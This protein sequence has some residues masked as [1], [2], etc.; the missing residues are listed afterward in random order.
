MNE[1][2]RDHSALNEVASL[3]GNGGVA[4]L[5]HSFLFHTMARS[6]KTLDR[7]LTLLRARA[8]QLKRR[9]VLH[10]AVF[11][12]VARGEDLPGSDVDIMIELDPA[13]RPT[14]LAYVGAVRE[15]Q[16]LGELL[17]RPIEVVQRRR[18]QPH[19]RPGLSGT[20]SLRSRREVSCQ[21]RMQRVGFATLSR[22]STASVPMCAG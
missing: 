3:V 4:P 14:V 9:G 7:V 16:G 8:A 5:S 22:T 13:G 1:K 15:I 17:G 10:A 11:G 2:R 6:D 21:R 20:P 19:V 18:L 12:S